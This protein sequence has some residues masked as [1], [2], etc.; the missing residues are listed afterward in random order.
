MKIKGKE[1]G[2]TV[3]KG[4]AK[5]VDDATVAGIFHNYLEEAPEYPKGK[6]DGKKLFRKGVMLAIIIYGYIDDIIKAFAN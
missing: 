1:L 3:L 4:V 6:I 2:K 5:L